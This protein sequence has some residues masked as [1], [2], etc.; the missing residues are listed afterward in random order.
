MQMN[1]LRYLVEAARLSSFSKA[2]EALF[3]TQPTLSQQ[4]R[5]LETE[6]DIDLFYRHSH[7][8]SLTPA[9]EEFYSAA[10]RILNESDNILA[11]MEDYRTLSQG[12]IRLGVFWLFAYLDLLETV[13]R[14]TRDHPGIDIT[15]IPGESEELLQSLLRHEIDAAVL[16]LPEARRNEPGFSSRS[17]HR[18]RYGVIVHHEDP[19]SGR[20]EIRIGD[21]RDHNVI[22]PSSV[23]CL[24]DLIAAERIKENVDFH[25]ISE[26]SHNEF[27]AWMVSQGIAV[28]FSTSAVAGKLNTGLFRWIPFVPVIEREIFL[29]TASSY[30][31][32][33]ALKKLVECLVE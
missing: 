3:V 10:C 1:Q 5:K 4:I 32:N 22:M 26:S 23:S 24:H 13:A 20:D 7:S 6:V 19:L 16:I 31:A 9:G 25:V 11:R 8:V 17:V 27:N 33:P 30:A 29:M 28:S 15:L 14:F 18:D 2:S 12:R 21:L